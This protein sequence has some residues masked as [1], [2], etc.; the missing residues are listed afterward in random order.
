MAGGGGV[1]VRVTPLQDGVGR[2][3]V[4]V[5]QLAAVLTC[6]T[7]C[8]HVGE[9][10]RVSGWVEM[11]TNR[12]VPHENSNELKNPNFDQQAFAPKLTFPSSEIWNK[13]LGDRFR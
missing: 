13:K 4:G 5:G 11:L 12:W 8:A 1:G 9:S 3:S 10:S 7:C 6:G 2:R